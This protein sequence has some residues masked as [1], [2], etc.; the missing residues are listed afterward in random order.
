MH[1][2]LAFR[3]HKNKIEQAPG[4]NN[5]LIKWCLDEAKKANL[6]KEDY[7]GAFVLDEMKIQVLPKFF[8]N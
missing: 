7:W 1:C 2:F 3:L 8:G 4:W 5:N 6:K